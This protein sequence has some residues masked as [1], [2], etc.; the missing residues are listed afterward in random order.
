M[1]KIKLLV[2]GIRCL[3]WRLVC[4]SGLLALLWN[5]GCESCTVDRA[6][7][8]TE[9]RGK[10]GREKKG[11][12]AKSTHQPPQR[13]PNPCRAK[14]AQL[15]DSEKVIH[16]RAKTFASCRFDT[17]CVLLSPT[18]IC[19]SSCGI[20][21]HPRGKMALQ[22]TIEKLQPLCTKL[23]AKNCLPQAEPCGEVEAWCDQGS[24][25][26]RSDLGPVNEVDVPAENQ[27]Q[28]PEPNASPTFDSQDERAQRLLQ[29]VVH[30]DPALAQDFFFPRE[31]FAKVKAMRNADAYWQRLLRRFAKDIHTLHAGLT[32]TSDLHFVR[33]ERSRRPSWMP[34][35]SEGNALPYWAARHNKLWYRQGN[36][37]HYLEVRV[38]ITWGKQWYLIHLLDW[39]T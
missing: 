20:A 3:T 32:R 2:S 39:K 5:A 16:Q 27:A 19:P 24:C 11:T 21:L 12:H 31:A 13:D 6:S 33:L 9:V 1:L 26:S 17:D 38:C 36:K 7:R 37:E 15:A 34:R 30:D 28:Q 8:S 25:R 18:R 22:P 35:G 14:L 23:H 4:L 10:E 29:A